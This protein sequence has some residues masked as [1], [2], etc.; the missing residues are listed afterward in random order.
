MMA[1]PIVTRELR[2]IARQSSTYWARVIIAASACVIGGFVLKL[3]ADANSGPFAK[4]ILYSVISSVLGIYALFSGIRNT[5]DNI[6]SEKR[7]GTLGLLFLTDLKGYDVVLG[8]L[9]STSINS[10]YGM[11]AAF[12]ILGIALIGGGITGN[13]FL[14][15]SL[16]LLNV[17]FFA[18][19]LGLV[20]SAYSIN[21]RRALGAGVSCG[22]VLMWGIPIVTSILAVK[23]WTKTAGWL[24]QLSPL[25][26][27]HMGIATNPAASGVL[28]LTG[29]LAPFITVTTFWRSLL[30][31]HVIGWFFLAIACWQAPRS[32][33][34]VDVKLNWRARIQHRWYGSAES[35]ALF[36]G[37]LVGINP[38]FWLASRARFDRAFTILWLTLATALVLA[39]LSKIGVGPMP[40]T[41]TLMIVLHLILRVN[42]ASS[43]SHHFAEQRR[44]GALEFLLACT[45]LNTPDIVR[46]QWL[47]LRRQF[48]IPLIAVI[49]LDSFFVVVVMMSEGNGTRPLVNDELAVFLTF[50]AAMVLMLIA[51]S[52][53]LGWVSMWM[54]ISYK[55]PTRASS[56]AISRIIVW[57]S[58]VMFFIAPQ[59]S[60]AHGNIYVVLTIWFCIGVLCDAFFI[61]HARRSLYAKFRA[62]AATPYEE[63]TGLMYKIGRAFGAAITRTD[64]ARGAAP[65]IIR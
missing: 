4:Q 38:F 42:I 7:E 39:L 8:K 21:G 40:L 46:G 56:A 36:R 15:G 17:I 58:L 5:A 41:I 33:Q 32:W 34:N 6:S 47:A 35:R 24:V 11:L 60:Y 3:I 12:P 23:H 20:I 37:K 44:S 27:L 57:P 54:G 1:L 61:V 25:N 62:L 13:E 52:V 30:V 16:A 10:Y 43:A 53:A 14:R 51:D 18:H 49:L 65:P 45:P 48:L 9:C 63:N 31:S 28:I 29:G 2:V 59:L 50:S 22:F 55:R 64:S 26:A 19:A